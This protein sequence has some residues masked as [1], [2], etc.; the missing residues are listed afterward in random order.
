[1]AARL[2]ST[3]LPSAIAAE[4]QQARNRRPDGHSEQETAARSI[5]IISLMA[6]DTA[7][8]TCSTESDD[9]ISRF[10]QHF[11]LRLTSPSPPIRGQWALPCRYG[12]SPSWI[13]SCRAHLW[14][15]GR[16]KYGSISLKRVVSD[17]HAV[18]C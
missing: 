2:H 1:M 11:A 14:T 7:T 18:S 10:K 12:S 8:I 5:A 9:Y 15:E 13:V 16:A 17:Y 4:Q 6:S 3:P